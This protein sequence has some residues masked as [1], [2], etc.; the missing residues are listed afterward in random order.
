MIMRDVPDV[1]FV[2]RCLCLLALA[3]SAWV[4]P[5]RGTRLEAAAHPPSNVAVF[6]SVDD[7]A[8]EPIAD[9][10]A[11]D[12]NIYEDDKIV[13]LDESRQTIVN[14][15]IAAAHYTLLLVD[16]SASVTASDQLG[17]IIAAASEFVAQVEPYQRVAVYAFD[18]SKN[19]YEVLPFSSAPRGSQALAGLQSFQSRDPSTNL[20]GALL[21][22]LSEL[23][24]AV[25]RANA[26]LRFGTLVVFT[27]GTDRA[28]RVP[29]QQMADAIEATSDQVYALGVGHEIDDS[30]LARIG[31]TGYIRVEDSAA[32]RSAF[33]EIADRIVRFTRHYYLLSYCSPARAGKHRVGIEAKH[34]GAHG[35]LDYDFDAEGFGPDCDPTRPPPFDTSGRTRKLRERLQRTP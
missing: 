22:A 3:L 33:R 29:F 4:H 13:S 15:Q 6:F 1:T 12:F 5:L 18:G 26:P 34:D 35:F 11:S 28:N 21:Q 32:S 8:G 25:D 19:L 7:W 2:P 31:K 20:N 24:K 16:M 27:D 23:D 9:L 14:P 30:T 17:A 10:L